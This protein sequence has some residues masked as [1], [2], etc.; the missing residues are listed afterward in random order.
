MQSFCGEKEISRNHP[1]IQQLLQSG[2][3][4]KTTPESPPRHPGPQRMISRQ[5]KTAAA[6]LP[7]VFSQGPANLLSY[8]ALTFQLTGACC[9]GGWN[10]PVLP[11]ASSGAVSRAPHLSGPPFLGSGHGRCHPLVS[12]APRDE[13]PVGQPVHCTDMPCWEVVEAQPQPQLCPPSPEHGWR[14]GTPSVAHRGSTSSQLPS[15]LAA[16]GDNS[17]TAT[18]TLAFFLILRDATCIQE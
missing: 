14:G 7:N 16:L 5:N 1:S 3:S 4:R 9:K 6:T 10:P 18:H 13:G 11:L 12:S 8:V 15:V 2:S 17:I